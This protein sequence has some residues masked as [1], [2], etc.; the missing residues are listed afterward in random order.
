MFLVKD[1]NKS[2]ANMN[3][4]EYTCTNDN[5]EPL[6]DTEIG[7]NTEQKIGKNNVNV[8]DKDKSKEYSTDDEEVNVNE[9]EKI[10]QETN[11]DI[12]GV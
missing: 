5:S 7:D 12:K 1:T 11:S 10:A 3:K 2:S 8:N 6:K 4:Q 9:T